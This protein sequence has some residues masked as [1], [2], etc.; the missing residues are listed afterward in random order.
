MKRGDPLITHASGRG[1][2]IDVLCMATR[3]ASPVDMKPWRAQRRP[4]GEHDV[5]IQLRYCGC[6][7]TDLHAIKGDLAVLM[8]VRGA[9][10]HTWVFVPQNLGASAEL[11]GGGGGP[12]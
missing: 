9:T 4:V 5:L 6:C 11:L 12:E 8:K 3:S 7:H 2:P 10:S 1:A